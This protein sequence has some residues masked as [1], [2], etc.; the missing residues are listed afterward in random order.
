MWKDRTKLLIS[1]NGTSILDN[2]HVAI[3]GVGGVGGFTAE[4]LVRAGIGNLTIV[5]F[6]KVDETNINRQYVANVETVGRL[7][8][9]VLKEMLL[10]IN[11]NCNIN[12]VAE[13]ICKENLDKIIKADEFD[14]VVDAI[15]SVTDKVE[16]IYYCESHKIKIVSAMGAGNRIDIPSFK[17]VDIYKTSNDGLAKVLRKK[18]RE[19]GVKKL[20]TVLCETVAQKID[21]RES[22]V[23][24]ISYYPAMCG[25]V[26]SAYVVQEL[27]KNEAK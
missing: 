8:T 10:K 13:K 27:L 1:E 12:A 2:A 5:D 23:G 3:V 6:D 26:L 20:D 17:I 11:P 15:D 18:L 21:K 25:C 4:M 24:S 22:A 16:L 9:E 14:I 7:K 19:K